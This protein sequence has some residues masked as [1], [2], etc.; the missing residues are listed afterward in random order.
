VA[1]AFGNPTPGDRGVVL[2]NSET[3]L[4]GRFGIYPQSLF[5]DQHRRP[6]EIGGGYAF[7]LF[8]NNNFSTRNRHGIFGSV[9]VLGGDWFVDADWRARITVRGIVQYFLLQERPGD[10]GGA[11]GAMGFEIAHFVQS[12]GEDG[13]IKYYGVLS[14]ELSIGLELFGGYYSVA[15]AD[16]GVFGVAITGRSP[17]AAGIGLLPLSSSF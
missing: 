9:D 13:Q 1:A 14:G 16:Y 4:D 7:Q 6:F 8:V 15:G 10:G 17:G 2:S 11:M 12:D 5:P 3:I